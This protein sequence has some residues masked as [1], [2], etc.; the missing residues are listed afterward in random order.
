ME[1][2]H[3]SAEQLCSYMESPESR[4]HGDIRRHLMGCNQCRLQIDNLSQLELDIKY[5]VPRFAVQHEITGDNEQRIERFVEHQFDDK[6]NQPME[7]EVRSDPD[8]LKS[9]LHYAVHSAA[10]S[11]NLENM[12]KPDIATA[13]T[14]T[15]STQGGFHQL[16][17]RIKQ[18]LQ[19]PMPAW[20]LAPAS[21][22]VAA[23][24][25]FVLVSNTT[26]QQQSVQIAT[27]QDD[28][29][30]TFERAGMPSGSIGFFHDAQS[31]SKPFTGIKI[32]VNKEVAPGD[33]GNNETKQLLLQWPAVEK[34]VNYKVRIY[35]YQNNEKQLLA[36]QSSNETQLR[37]ENL[38]LTNGQHYEWQL[39][40]DTENGLKF[41]T[42]GDFVY[43]E[44]L[45][46]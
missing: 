22:A 1:N 34:A 45:S 25:S 7:T 37:F 11:R 13:E 19:W 10:M 43:L 4:E 46:N 6:P 29:T 21:F 15:T 24:I 39:S 32:A 28:A 20:A 44:S 3:P 40:G 5:F 16:L 12:S 30:I 38:K 8:A 27:Y 26:N 14:S 2:Q 42:S 35:H 23:V 36:Q 33:D 17:S 31:S 18:S 9:A 41:T